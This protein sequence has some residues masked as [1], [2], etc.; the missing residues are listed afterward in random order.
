MN[1]DYEQRF[2]GKGKNESRCMDKRGHG[3]VEEKERKGVEQEEGHG[4][5]APALPPANLYP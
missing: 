2:V 3:E 1:G 4:L 5:G